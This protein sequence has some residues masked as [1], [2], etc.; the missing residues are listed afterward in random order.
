MT[1]TT[2]T[3]QGAALVFR[4]NGQVQT[5]DL[6]QQS[7]TL[8]AIYE[9][10]DCPAVRVLQM[11]ERLELWVD[12]EG[13]P[14]LGVN[15]GATLLARRYGFTGPYFGDVRLCGPLDHEYRSVNLTRDQVCAVAT[16]LA[17]ELDALDLDELEQELE[18][19]G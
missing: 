13:G 17:N 15:V 12:G 8:A 18:R 4:T 19:Q 9:Q 11:T 1:D 16:T 2:I 5:I 6:S 3:E 14:E 7:G 10:L